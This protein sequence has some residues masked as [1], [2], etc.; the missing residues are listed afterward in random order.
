MK[1]VPNGREGRKTA[2]DGTLGPMKE[3]AVPTAG[4]V[5]IYLF[6]PRIPES[7]ASYQIGKARVTK[8]VKVV[9]DQ[10]EL[11]KCY[12]RLKKNKDSATQKKSRELRRRR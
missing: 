12:S 11:R 4:K 3:R 9:T 8:L 10:F 2:R 5:V 7:N 1:H 6:D